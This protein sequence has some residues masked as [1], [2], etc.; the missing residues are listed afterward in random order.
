MFFYDHSVFNTKKMDR[1]RKMAA[2][3]LKN[4]E[5]AKQKEVYKLKA[6]KSKRISDGDDDYILPSTSGTERPSV[7]NVKTAGPTELVNDP[8]S[9]PHEKNSE[10]I[11]DSNFALENTTLTKK[12]CPRK[13]QKSLIPPIVR[14]SEK[15]NQRKAAHSLKEPCNKLCKKKSCFEF[16]E[17][18]RT[19]IHSKF[20]GLTAVEQKWF[21]Y[22]HVS[23]TPPKRRRSATTTRSYTA[24]Y[25]LSTES[26]IGV[27]VC[28]TFFLTTLGFKPKDDKTLRN[29]IASKKDGKLCGPKPDE[30]GIHSSKKSLNHKTLVESHIQS[31][32]PSISHYRRDHAP[33]R[34][35][36][37]SD[38]TI[39]DMHQNFVQK[40][41]MHISYELYRRIFATKGI[42][43]AKLGHEECWSCE[44]RLTH[45]KALNHKKENL[46]TNCDI[47]CEWKIHFEKYTRSREEYQKD[48]KELN[49]DKNVLFASVD[50]QKVSLRL[51]IGNKYT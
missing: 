42:S 16:S 12:G 37:P 25:T 44:K 20:W 23:I 36:L 19:K 2:L 48:A 1:G 15:W 41:E 30:R 34:K 47:C 21:L 7:T 39:R 13:R 11:I 24:K 40:Y 51:I 10:E 28:K 9:S 46:V 17:E 45:E 50:L 38:I 29:V 6:K 31:Y 32:N 8:I 22:N 3:A 35:Y 43:F 14:K 33:N 5:L 4:I 18:Q 27:E 49:T 26:G